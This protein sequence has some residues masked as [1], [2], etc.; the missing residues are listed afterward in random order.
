MLLFLISIILFVLKHFGLIN[1][2]D[3]LIS[4]PAFTMAAFSSW[5]FIKAEFNYF[6]DLRKAKKEEIPAEQ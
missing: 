4:L 3:W 6:R 1:W 2:A 5:L